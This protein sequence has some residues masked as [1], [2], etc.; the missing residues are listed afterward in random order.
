MGGRPA[1]VEDAEGP[2]TAAWLEP[3]SLLAELVM[4]G[5][6]RDFGLLLS[7]PAVLVVA[8]LAV[9][10]DA[11]ALAFHPEAPT[12]AAA[13]TAHYVH[14][15]AGHLAGN[16]GVYA[17]AVGLGYPLAVLGGC[18]RRFITMIVGVLLAVPLVLSG[19][20]LGLGGTAALIGF[21]GIALALV[22][23]LPP[24]VFEYLRSRVSA[25]FAVTDAL[26]LFLVGGAVI[27]WQASR[28][29]PRGELLAA[30]VAAVGLAT[31][32]PVGWRVWQRRQRIGPPTRT[33]TAPWLP[34]AAGLGFLLAVVT[35]TAG[36]VPAEGAE[37]VLTLHLLGY[38]VGFVGAYGNAHYHRIRTLPPPPGIDG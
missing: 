13:F 12:A 3:P 1:P 32:G 7:I 31:L 25:A 23:L 38:A 29:I 19:V 37:A 5:C 6:R 17:V 34:L 28:V 33:R 16:L 2:V 15:S 24:V 14:A 10:P 30:G 9:G 11:A 8:W 27:T 21:S 26:G 20:H 22:G 4:R 35:A 18:R 36:P